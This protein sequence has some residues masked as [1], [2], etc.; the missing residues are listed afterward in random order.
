MQKIFAEHIFDK[1]LVSRIYKSSYN[2]TAK[3]QTAQLKNWLNDLKDIFPGIYTKQQQKHEKMPNIISHQSRGVKLIFMGA[4]ISPVVA[5]KGPNVI[6]GLY[7]CNYSLTR[8]KLPDR[9]KV[10]GWIKKG[11]GPDS[12]AGL[13]FATCALEKR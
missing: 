8:G 1:G 2:F 6:G 9:N 12:A 5:F 11:R 10:L 13:A 3:R 7:K 4:H